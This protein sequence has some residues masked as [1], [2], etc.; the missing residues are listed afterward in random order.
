MSVFEESAREYAE[1]SMRSALQRELWSCLDD[2]REYIVRVYPITDTTGQGPDFQIQYTLLE[3][4]Y[5]VILRSWQD[6]AVGEECCTLWEPMDQCPMV[7]NGMEFV[8]V[9]KDIWRRIS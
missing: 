3:L 1:N 5:N 7:I 6:A 8:H 2:G 4:R 9:S